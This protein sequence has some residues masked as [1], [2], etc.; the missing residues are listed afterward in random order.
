MRN[1][2]GAI[3]LI[4]DDPD[5]LTVLANSL[6]HF[7]YRTFL[8][9][10]AK[11][12]LKVIEEEWRSIDCLVL[13]IMMPGDQDGY[14]VME[15]LK[16][17]YPHADI[18]VV[19]LSARSAADDIAKS[20]NLGA[21]Q[22]MSKPCDI[23][24]LSSVIKNIVKLRGIERDSHATAQKFQ[25]IFDN[26]PA[27]I[28]VI[29][30]DLLIQETNRNF[31]ENFPQCDIGD[32]YFHAMHGKDYQIPKEHPIIKALESG[33][34]ETGRIS[35]EDEKGARHFSIKVEPISNDEGETTSL[36]VI[37]VDRTKTMN[38]E[39]NLRGQVERYN[40]V[41]R[42]QDR[43][44]DYL[45]QAQKELQAKGAELERLSLTDSLTELNNRRFFDNALQI[46]ARRSSRYMHPLSLI[47]IDIDYFKEVN[48][49]YG[50]PAGDAVL[51]TLAKILTATLRETDII[52]RYGGEEF[53]IILP[54]TDYDT[55]LVIAERLRETVEATDFETETI[56]LSITIS[57]GIASVH[58]KVINP[59]RFLK[60]AD[61]CLYDSKEQGRNC[62]NGLKIS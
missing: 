62:I 56:T 50:H 28:A 47:M 5:A 17:N 24:H 23:T 3:L 14:Y 19:V 32:N 34:L 11:D 39:N 18:P 53:T 21:F 60:A 38:M 26:T 9:R 13:D 27:Q 35:Y 48:D 41:L 2:G 61:K 1:E 25:V 49:T 22:H 4:D 7:G 54:E 40:R 52:C 36:V 42:E 33:K 55:G 45:I 10:N 43:T 57:V 29:S 31:R 46:E 6:E 58:K 37:R 51:L 20:Y 16:T 15:C 30:P 8:A 59:Q 44:T 12:G